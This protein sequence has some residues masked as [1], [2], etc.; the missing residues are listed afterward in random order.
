MLNC[1]VRTSGFL[2]V[3]RERRVGEDVIR[4]DRE[5]LRQLGDRRVHVTALFEHHR[6]VVHF[7]GRCHRSSLDLVRESSSRE[8][9]KFHVEFADASLS[10]LRSTSIIATCRTQSKRLATHRTIRRLHETAPATQS[11]TCG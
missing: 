10:T 4:I 7:V 8:A 9:G 5:N 11:S 1:L 3:D 6:F 2:Q